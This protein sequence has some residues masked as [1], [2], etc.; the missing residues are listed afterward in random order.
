MLPLFILFTSFLSFSHPV[1]YQGGFVYWGSFKPSSN[2][3]RASYSFHHKL[4]FELRSEWIKKSSYRDYTGGFNLLLKRF[5]FN[6]SQ[7]NL[8][9]SH[10]FG[11]YNEQRN[12]GFVNKASLIGD[13]ESRTLYTALNVSGKYINRLKT[14]YSGRIGFAPYEGDL[15]TLQS[16]LVL[17][18]SY[19]EE[20]S[21]NIVIT[22]MLRFFYQNVLWELG[23]TS[24]SEYFFTLMVHY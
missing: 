20:L 6:K 1:I 12:D 17:Q 19:N 13:W 15:E 11:Y 9:L 14:Q 18:A 4:S 5:L 8:Y 16:W 2:I 22:P 10:Q 3:Q 23:A 7:G 21:K 24:K